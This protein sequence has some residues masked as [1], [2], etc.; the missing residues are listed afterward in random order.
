MTEV[1][2]K[3]AKNENILLVENKTKCFPKKSN[4]KQLGKI[5]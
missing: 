2:K 3:K 1:I 4:Q 5:T